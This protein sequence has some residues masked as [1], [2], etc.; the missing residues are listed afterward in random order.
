MHHAMGRLPESHD[1]LFVHIAQI[2]NWQKK[3][4]R[5]LPLW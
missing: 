4:D 5:T 2:K 1:M 3:L